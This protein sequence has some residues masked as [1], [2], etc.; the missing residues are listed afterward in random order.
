VAWYLSSWRTIPFPLST[1]ALTVTTMCIWRPSIHQTPSAAWGRA[2]PLTQKNSVSASPKT[3]SVS[4]AKNSHLNVCKEIGAVN[5]TKHAKCIMTFNMWTK[6]RV[7]D[8]IAGALPS[9]FKRFVNPALFHYYLI[10]CSLT[11]TPY[12]ICPL[13]VFLTGSGVTRRVLTDVFTPISLSLSH[14]MQ[15]LDKSSNSALV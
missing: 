7:C 14:P 15:N 3:Q 9:N 8:F 6:C 10:N 13:C 5:S 12:L 1:S 2:M 11:D 4:S